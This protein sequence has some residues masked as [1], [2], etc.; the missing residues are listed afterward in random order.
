MDNL[1]S[2]T[3]KQLKEYAEEN[4]ID[5]DK[6]KTKTQIL[7]ILLGTEPIVSAPVE[8]QTVI[9]SE[10]PV[11]RTPMSSSG[12]NDE[13]TVISRPAERSVKKTTKTLKEEDTKVAL[14][15]EKNMHW[16][17]VGNVKKGYNIVTKEAAKMWLQKKGVREASS[18]EVATY[19]GKS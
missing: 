15:S 11:K 12:A 17:G 1:S 7:S 8:E 3:V 14:F 9:T 16:L 2:K 10:G 18:E 6:A 13:G 5:L 4:N 19:Y